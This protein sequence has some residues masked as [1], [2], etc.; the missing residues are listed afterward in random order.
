VVIMTWFNNYSKSRFEFKIEHEAKIHCGL[1]CRG[2]V[3]HCS[4]YSVTRGVTTLTLKRNLVL[5]FEKEK[6]PNRNNEQS[7]VSL[8]GDSNSGWRE[9]RKSSLSKVASS[10]DWLFHWILKNLIVLCLVT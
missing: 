4:Y 3:E 9:R 7:H 1:H 8:C 10:S 5:R 2:N 6:G